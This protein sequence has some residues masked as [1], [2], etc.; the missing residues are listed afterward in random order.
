MQTTKKNNWF[1]IIGL[2][3]AGLCLL[4]CLSIAAIAAFFPSL[5]QVYLK[6]S[7]LTI[8]DPAPGFELRALTG[9]KVRLSQFAGQ[10]VLL[11]FSA[12]WCPG[13]RAEAPLLQELHTSHPE[14]VILLVDMKEPR[15]DVKDFAE[16]FGM[17]FPVLL[18]LDGRVSNQYQVLAIPTGLFIDQEGIIRAKLIES[19]T[20]ELLAKYLP[21]IGV[22]P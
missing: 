12:S 4:G 20:P 6:N 3:L 11:N 17:T 16:E 18:D 22:Q 15:N 7:S 9:E 21:L 10:P 19:V 5:Y 2:S 8:G 1:L 13:C 14:L